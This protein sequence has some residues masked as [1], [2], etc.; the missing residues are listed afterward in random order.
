MSLHARVEN[1]AIVEVGY[2]DDPTGWVPVVDRSHHG[3]TGPAT[4]K[5]VDGVV[6][7]ARQAETIPPQV[8]HERTIRDAIPAALDH[9]ATIRARMDAIEAAPSMTVAQLNT[10]VKAQAGAIDDMAAIV[11]RVLR[12]IDG[13]LDGTD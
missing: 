8:E 4:Y 11:R 13:R 5:L 3:R 10:A 1:G 7:L 12:L 9:L 2:P 6:V